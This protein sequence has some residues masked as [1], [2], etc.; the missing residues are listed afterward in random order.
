MGAQ[1]YFVACLVAGQI[2]ALVFLIAGASKLFAPVR[3]RESVEEYGLLPAPVAGP[4]AILLPWMEL[5]IAGFLLMRVLSDYALL[6]GASLLGVFT[7]AQAL[8]LLRGQSVACGCF[9][10]M[11]T[12]PVR[13]LNAATNLVLIVCCLAGLRAG[14]P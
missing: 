14:E 10:S 2:P 6:T 13:W 7:L 11:S 1:L 12:G 5:A 8:V 3:T 4:L 9:G